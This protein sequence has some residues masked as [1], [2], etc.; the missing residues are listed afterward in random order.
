ME[1]NEVTVEPMK[2]GEMEDSSWNIGWEEE[3]K[4]PGPLGLLGDRKQKGSNS[5][6]HALASASLPLFTPPFSLSSAFVLSLSHCQNIL[7]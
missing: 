2:D 1:Q 5:F 6:I 3:V 7:S 4:D